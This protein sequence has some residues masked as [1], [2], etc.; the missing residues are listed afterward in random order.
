VFEFNNCCL[1]IEEWPGQVTEGG[2]ERQGGLMTKERFKQIT[3]GEAKGLEQTV[4]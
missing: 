2:E 3:E 1:R 4:V